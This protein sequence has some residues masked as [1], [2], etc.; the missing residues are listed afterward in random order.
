MEEDA[1]RCQIKGFVIFVD[2]QTEEEGGE[3]PKKC[4]PMQTVSI[5]M[6]EGRPDAAYNS[7]RGQWGLN[8]SHVGPYQ[9]PEPDSAY[10]R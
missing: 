6:E 1:A 4:D 5:W 7:M 10:T 2:P 3:N 9:P 8:P